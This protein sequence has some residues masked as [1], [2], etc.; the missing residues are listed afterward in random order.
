MI[1][2]DNFTLKQLGQAYKNSAII[3]EKS[4][5]LSRKYYVLEVK[6]KDGIVNSALN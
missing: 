2:S 4:W 5:M 3:Q 1:L 6:I